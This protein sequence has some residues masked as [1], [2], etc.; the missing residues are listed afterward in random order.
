MKVYDKAVN[1]VCAEIDQNIEQAEIFAKKVNE[2]NEN[3]LL[4]KK[5]YLDM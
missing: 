1:D 2:L 4:M 3:L 5:L